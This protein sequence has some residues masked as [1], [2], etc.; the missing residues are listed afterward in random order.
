MA[1][2]G[3]AFSLGMVAVNFYIPFLFNRVDKK[4]CGVISC[5]LQAVCCVAT[6]FLGTSGSQVVIAFLG[7]LFGFTHFC[8]NVAVTLAGEII[9]DNW[10]RTG[11]RSDGVIY[12]CISFGTKFGNAIGGSVGILALGAA[13]YVANTEMSSVVISRMNTIINFAPAIIFLIAAI[14]F[15]MI[16]MTNKLGKENEIKIKQMTETGELK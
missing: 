9:D 1:V 5:I 2:F 7:F 10:L 14:P 16:H 15:S 6:F 13:G 4:T 3:T 8:G 11:T 12:S